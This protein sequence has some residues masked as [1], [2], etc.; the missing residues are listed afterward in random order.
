MST[1]RQ[2]ESEGVPD[3]EE[4][5]VG[6]CMDYLAGAQVG[7]V[8][9]V[10]NGHPAILPVNYILDGEQILYRTDEGTDLSK[11]GLTRV[12]FEVDHIDPTSR[13]GWSVLVQGRRTILATPSTGR[14]N[15]FV[16]GLQSRGRP[17]S[18]IAGSLSDR[19]RSPAAGYVSNLSNSRWE[20]K[21]PARF[22]RTAQRSHHLRTHCRM[23]W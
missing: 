7:R 8:A 4:L 1:P 15:G 19:P 3:L 16:V 9:L 18:A 17:E 6:E 21:S 5:S 12:A 20:T 22:R 23:S 14:R 2:H 11:A 13:Q 10:V